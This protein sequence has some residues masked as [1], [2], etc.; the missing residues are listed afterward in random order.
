[1]CQYD[2]MHLEVL[3]NAGDFEPIVPTSAVWPA[4]RQAVLSLVKPTPN[5]TRLFSVPALNINRPKR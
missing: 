5:Y 4:V 3:P 2:E 1:M